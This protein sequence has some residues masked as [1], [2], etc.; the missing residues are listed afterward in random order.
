MLPI[1]TPVILAEL[2]S[3]KALLAKWEE[4]VGNG[5]PG[6]DLPMTG[7]SAP[8]DRLDVWLTEFVGELRLISGKTHNLAEILAGTALD[9]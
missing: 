8:A 7:N 1:A 2:E 5:V 3:L 6:V 4:K 9:Y